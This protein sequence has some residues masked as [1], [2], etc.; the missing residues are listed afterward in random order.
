M[1]AML[2]ALFLI[3]T[4]IYVVLGCRSLIELILDMV[5]EIF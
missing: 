5:A 2:G 4:V 1:T 3:L